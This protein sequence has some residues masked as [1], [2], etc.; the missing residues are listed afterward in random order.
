LDH[1]GY[2]NLIRGLCN[3]GKFSLAFEILDDMLDRNLT[4]CL[5]VSVLLIPQLCKAQRY[6]KAIALKEFILKEHP[7]FPHAANHGLICGFCNTGNIE[8]ADSLF[9]DI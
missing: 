5:D 8:K 2:N 1:A 3:E 6:D 9:R 7:S 4:P